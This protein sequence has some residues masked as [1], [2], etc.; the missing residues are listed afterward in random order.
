M[1]RLRI[2][3]RTHPL[4]SPLT[5]DLCD[6]FRCRF[7]G[8]MGRR[9]LARDRGLLFRWPREGRVDTA[10]HMLFMRFPIAVIW[11]D[12]QQRVVDARLARPWV[13][14]LMPQK[15]AQYV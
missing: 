10:I 6:T 11:L 4:K 3:N 9:S 13:D 14:F 1:H 8:L 7:L 12:A 2:E 5:L 15:A